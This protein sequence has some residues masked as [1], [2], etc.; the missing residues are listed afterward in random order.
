MTKVEKILAYKS[1]E[2]YSA[3]KK[4]Q[5]NMGTIEN[6]YTLCNYIDV[7]YEA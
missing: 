4:W 2:A 6:G 1:D 7:Y 3:Y 5:K